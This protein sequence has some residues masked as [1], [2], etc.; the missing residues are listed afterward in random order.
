MIDLGLRGKMVTAVYADENE[1]GW[2]TTVVEFS[3]GTGLRVVAH[4]QEEA[5]QSVDVIDSAA[6]DALVTEFDWR[7]QERRARS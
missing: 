3:D 7:E 4:S 1:D 5:Y 2:P 6:V